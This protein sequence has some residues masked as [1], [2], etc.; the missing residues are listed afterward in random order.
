M[1]MPKR[2]L[3]EFKTDEEA[4]EFWDTHDLAEYWDQMEVVEDVTF[5]PSPLKLKQVCLRLS[6]TQIERVKRIARSKGI[7]YQ[8]LL[9]MW[10]TEREHQEAAATPA[11]T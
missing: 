11:D 5:G 2:K 1:T 9:R 6:P 10:I 4:G 7:G 3:P 8:T